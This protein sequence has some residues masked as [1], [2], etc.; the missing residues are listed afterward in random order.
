MLVNWH[1]ALGL[2]AFATLTAMALGAHAAQLE[3][4]ATLPDSCSV[5]GGTLAFGTVNP[6]G[7]QTPTANTTFNVQCSTAGS[8]TVAL[9]GGLHHGQGSNGRAM[10]RATSNTYLNYEL[11]TSA[12]QTTAWPVPGGVNKTVAVGANAVAVYGAIAANQVKPGGEYSD[13]VQI[14]LTVN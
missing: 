8:V 9:D 1:K 10:K 4:T 6:S 3:V 2:A 13:T 7:G 5:E 12:T 14:S 11:Y